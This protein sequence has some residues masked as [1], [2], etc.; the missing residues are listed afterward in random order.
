V[1]GAIIR[2]ANKS[3][4]VIYKQVEQEKENLIDYMRNKCGVTQLIRCVD[5]L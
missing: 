4:L 1:D 3:R 2:E 5:L